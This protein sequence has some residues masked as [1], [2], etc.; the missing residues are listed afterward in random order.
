MFDQ[1]LEIR[2]EYYDNHNDFIQNISS[3]EARSFPVYGFI[4]DRNRIEFIF[5]EQ[6]GLA[7]FPIYWA[8]NYRMRFYI[9][10]IHNETIIYELAR[11]IIDKPVIDCIAAVYPHMEDWTD[12][13][14]EFQWTPICNHHLGTHFLSNLKFSIEIKQWNGFFKHATTHLSKRL[15]KAELEQLNIQWMLIPVNSWI[16]W[17]D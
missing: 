8:H 3:L 1:R 17:D 2:Y 12:L 6:P 7:D 14:L 15:K 5:L 10:L 4:C 11:V 16:R 13:P 9:R